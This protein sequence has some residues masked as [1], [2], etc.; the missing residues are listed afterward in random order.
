MTRAFLVFLLLPALLPAAT[1]SLTITGLGGEADFEQRFAGWSADIAKALKNAPGTTAESLQGD[2]ARI[3][4]IR[5]AF[6]RIAASAK[7]DDALIVMLIGHGTFDGETYKLNVPGPDMTGRDLASL[8]DSVPASRQLVVNMTSASGAS[9]FPLR[10]EGRVVI[11]ATKSGTEKNATIFA[12]YWAEA[13]NDPAADA[14]KND[15]ISALEAFRYA[16]RKTA[17]FYTAQKRLATEHPVLEDTGK[18]EGVREPSPANGYGLLASAFPVLR[19]AE[20]AKV[21]DPAKRELRQRKE[22]IEQRI[23]QLKYQKAAMPIETYRK[24]LSAML[25]ELARVQ[26]ELD[27]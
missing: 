4:S 21:D 22:Q 3:E 25:L 27:K 19:L 16:E 24:Q 13:L 9:I 17:T 10:K 12:R 8:M 11:S 18:G 7:A 1:Y 2:S 6:G 15:T 20:A 14:D 5:A 23:D 26:A